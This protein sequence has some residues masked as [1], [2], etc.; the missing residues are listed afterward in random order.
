MQANKEMLVEVLTADDESVKQA[1]ELIV[2]THTKLVKSMAY[3]LAQH[4]PHSIQVEDLMQAGMI[5]LLEAYKHYDPAKGASFET[6]AGIRVRG[7]MLDEV[8]RHEWVP[9]SVY[10]NARVVNEAVKKIENRLGRV[11]KDKE[12]ADELALDM[13]DYHELVQ[14]A[15]SSHW[16]GFDDLGVTEDVLKS[17]MGGTNEPHECVLHDDNAHHL[18]ELIKTLPRNEQLVVAL[19]YE[20]DLNLKE[21]GE[22]LDVSESRIS[23]IH[24]QAMQHLKSRLKE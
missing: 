22:V 18:A 15:A 16:Y 9:R 12:V 21:I 4:L 24:T 7:Y 11:A 23:Q 5:G 13:D 17:D 8:R 1:E 20:Q 19:Y 3:H 14:D 6:Y 2:K 10:R